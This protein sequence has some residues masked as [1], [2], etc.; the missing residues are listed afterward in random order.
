MNRSTVV[1]R[2]A[3]D[4]VLHAPSIMPRQPWWANL[5]SNFYRQ[6][7]GFELDLSDHVRVTSTAAVDVLLRTLGASTIGMTAVPIGFHPL[8]LWSMLK[9]AEF[10]KSLADRADP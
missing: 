1:S 6:P 3:H 2:I 7:E 10:Y 5:A 9:D 8:K 4:S